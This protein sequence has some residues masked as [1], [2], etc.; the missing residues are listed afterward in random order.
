MKLFI[1]MILLSLSVFAQSEDV[2]RRWTY[3]TETDCKKSAAKVQLY[4]TQEEISPRKVYVRQNDEVCLLVEAVD[5]S[6][7]LR[8]E[9]LPVLLTARKGK[10]EMVY[11]RVPK[12]GEYKFKCVGCADGKYFLGASLVV[13]TMQEFDAAQEEDLRKNSE[14]YRKQIVNPNYKPRDLRDS[15]R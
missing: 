9:K 12:A 4:V 14:K 2:G 7:N 5:T 3:K 6:V 13:Q 11:F 15:G 1:T 10:T 8:I